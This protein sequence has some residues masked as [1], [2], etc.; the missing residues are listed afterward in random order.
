LEAVTSLVLT[1]TGSS[2]AKKYRSTII[3]KNEHKSS[4][5]KD[6]VRDGGANRQVPK[7]SAAIW[8]NAQIAGG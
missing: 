6:T 5:D 4:I 7:K 1:G 8:A 2:I 3:P